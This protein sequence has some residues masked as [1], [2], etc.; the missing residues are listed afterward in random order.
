[1]KDRIRRAYIVMRDAYSSLRGREAPKAISKQEIASSAPAAPPRKDEG[2][3]SFRNTQFARRNTQDGS[4]LIV[5]LWSLFFLSALAVA[6]SAYVR[7]ELDL[8]GKLMDRTKMYY[9]ANAGVK[10]AILEIDRDETDTYDTLSDVWSNNN[11]VFTKT[12]V[13]DGSFSIV[14]RLADEPVNDS[15]NLPFLEPS[16]AQSIDGQAEYGLIDEG[17]KININKVPHSVL[18]KLFEITCEITSDEA[19]DIADSIIDWR[20]EDDEPRDNG[21][22]D[23]YYSRLKS[24][25]PCKDADFEILEELLLVKGLTQEKFDKVKDLITV[26]SEGFVN[27]NTAPGLTLQALGMTEELV[28]KVMCFRNGQGGEE[29]GEYANVFEDVGSIADTLNAV[30]ELSNGEIAQINKIFSFGL[31]SVRSDNF[32]GQSLGQIGNKGDAVSIVFVFDR[33]GKVVKYWRTE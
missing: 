25:Y 9:L 13:D 32:M 27:I 1:M 20:D 28:E 8:A 12:E 16:R 5:I 17:R 31:L 26:Y 4:I 14:S 7:P 19:S 30:E 6:I 15:S 33:E 23:D 2:R 29:P 18:K 22:E 10:R 3:A 11:N 21:A 24:G